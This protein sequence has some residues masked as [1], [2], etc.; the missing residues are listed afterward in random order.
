[1]RGY[2]RSF[3]VTIVMRIVYFALSDEVDAEK[4]LEQHEVKRW[5]GVAKTCVTSVFGLQYQMI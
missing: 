3:R 4:M 5:I 2:K 1:M